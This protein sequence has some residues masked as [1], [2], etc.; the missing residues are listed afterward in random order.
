MSRESE[1]RRLAR[2]ED[3]KKA[4]LYP[5]KKCPRCHRKL[6][7]INFRRD[8]RTRMGLVYLCRRCEKEKKKG[9]KEKKI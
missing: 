9:E 8:P 5:R 7:R 1:E 3:E 6:S 4:R 2:I